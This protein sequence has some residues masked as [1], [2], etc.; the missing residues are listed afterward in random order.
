MQWERCLTKDTMYEKATQILSWVGL[1]G[2]VWDFW[3]KSQSP[4]ADRGVDRHE[5]GSWSLG[6]KCSVPWG[7]ENNSLT[8]SKSLHLY[9]YQFP[10]LK[11][12]IIIMVPLLL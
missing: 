2:D 12:E 4:R 5:R 1:V 9:E 3:R 6:D 8:G 11:M 7:T 10:F